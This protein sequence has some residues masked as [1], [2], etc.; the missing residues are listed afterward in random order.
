MTGGD[1]DGHDLKHTVKCA[2]KVGLE[3]QHD[4]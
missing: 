2:K 1:S 4:L 3:E